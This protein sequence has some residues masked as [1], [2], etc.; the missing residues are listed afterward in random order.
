M[1]EYFKTKI[2]YFSL[3]GVFNRLCQKK[4]ISC[5]EFT[6][7]EFIRKCLGRFLI[8]KTP[9]RLADL[10]QS[11]ALG[12][13]F[14]LQFFP[15]P[16]INLIQGLSVAPARCRNQRTFVCDF[17]AHLCLMWANSLHFS[18]VQSGL[19]L[20]IGFYFTNFCVFKYDLLEGKTQDTHFSH[21]FLHKPIGPCKEKKV[22]SNQNCLFA[23]WQVAL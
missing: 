9:Q 4:I 22:I 6:T 20:L 3:T 23:T 11:K 15:Q 8:S 19:S 16:R 2:S 12:L 10:T 14:S 18:L 5:R 7:S 13:D 1:R 21:A 17:F